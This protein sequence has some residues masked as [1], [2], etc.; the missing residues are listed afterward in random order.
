MEAT[1]PAKKTAETANEVVAEV[2]PEETPITEF[3]DHQKKAAN[4]AAKALAAL[5]PQG[6]REH[7][8]AAIKEMV[9]GYR[10]LVNATL[11]QIIST[12]EKAKLEK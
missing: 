10:K 8:D 9:E 2:T 4:E 1:M 11:D 3:I 7:G 12:V 5:V 6:V